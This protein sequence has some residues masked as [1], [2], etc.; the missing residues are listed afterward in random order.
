MIFARGTLLAF[1]LL[2]VGPTSLARADN[3]PSCVRPEPVELLEASAKAGLNLDVPGEN[4]PSLKVGFRPLVQA[5][6]RLQWLATGWFAP[7][8]GVLFVLDCAGA[9]VA[10][11][12]TGSIRS[13]KKGPKL[14]IGETVEIVFVSGYATGEHSTSVG[15]ARFD[16]KDIELVWQHVATYDITIEMVNSDYGDR[17][18]WRISADGKKIQVTGRRMV[19]ELKDPD[20]GWPPHSVHALPAESFRWKDREKRYLAC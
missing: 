6:K 16:G 15:L 18:R 17:F 14:S 7:P 4:D 3:E 1:C 19:R 9:I 12:R 13:L 11:K 2:C 8:D 5:G 10:A 20:H